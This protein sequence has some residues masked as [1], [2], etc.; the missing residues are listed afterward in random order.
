MITRENAKLVIVED[1]AIIAADLADKLTRSGYAISGVFSHG[2]AAIDHIRDRLPDLVLMDIHLPG[3]LDGVETAEI[4]R[5]E[6]DLPIIFLTAHS[7]K[8]TLERVKLTEPFG[9]LLKPLDVLALETHV[10]MALYK[11]QVELSLRRGHEE[12]EQHVE[13]RTRELR[14]A[15]QMLKEAN[16]NLER[17]VAERTAELEA[18]NILLR[19]SRRAALNMMEDAEIA[20]RKAEE[21]SSE[22]RRETLER[23]RAEEKLAAVNLELEKRVEQ[24][25]LE[26]QETHKQYLHAE[27]LSAI[28]KLSASIAHEFNNPLQGILSILKG[29]KKRAIL[30]DEDRELLEAAI[31]ESERMKDLIRSLQEFNRPSPNRLTF[32]DVHKSLDSILLLNKSDFKGKRIEV[33]RDYAH[34]LPPIQAVPDQIKQ[35]F[36]NLLANAADACQ[37]EGGVITVSTRQEGEQV[38]VAIK[39]T[40]IGIKPEDIDRIFQPFFTTKPAIKGT[41]LGLS[42]SY[43]IVKHHQGIIEVE[44]GPGLGSTFT[45]R[46]PINSCIDQEHPAAG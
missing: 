27:K 2:E 40:G 7:D 14:A 37:H 10:E 28:G 44:S 9:C 36:L 42:V 23:K 25:T 13:N 35:V 11:H 22:L 39:D 21:T 41:G 38:A 4:I 31:G 15:Q 33:V 43:G 45:V 18:A 12:L 19:D 17:R 30:D 46:L 16:E 34:Q 29:L 1:E 6:F 20:R 26:L 3:S 8:T 24:R 32:F 5:R